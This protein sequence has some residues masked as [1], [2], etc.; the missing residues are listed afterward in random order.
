[1]AETLMTVSAFLSMVFA[2]L[3]LLLASAWLNFAPALIVMGSIIGVSFSLAILR[4]L[5]GIE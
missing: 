3:E 1:M 2:E 5:R 4:F